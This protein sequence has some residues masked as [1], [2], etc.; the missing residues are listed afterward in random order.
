[1]AGLYAGE[2]IKR[3]VA[4]VLVA[5][6]LG[7]ALV[8]VISVE[9]VPAR[10]ANTSTVEGTPDLNASAPDARLSAGQEGTVGITITNDATIEDD[11][12]THPAEAINRAGEARSVRVN[13]TDTEDAP[14]TVETGQQSGGTIQDGETSGP[15]NFNVLVDED[16]KAGTYEMEV[17]TR[18]R[19]AKTVEYEQTEPGTYQY[20]EEV[21][22]RTETETITVVIEPEA[23]FEIT[24]IDHNIPLGGEGM[25]GLT[26]ENTGDEDITE[27][28]V[29]VNSGDS[30]LYFGSGTATSEAKIGAWDAGETKRVV[31]RA[32][33]V[34]AAVQ[35]SYPVDLTVD[36]T[37]S[38]NNQASGSEQF[39]ITPHNRTRFEV[40]NVSH[41]VPRDGTGTFT[42]GIEHTADKTISDVAVTASTSE[43]EVSLGSESSRSA[44]AFVREWESGETQNLTFRIGASAN[45]V[46][47]S[48]PIE[49]SFEYTDENNSDNTRTEFVE[50]TPK[51]RPQFSV[52]NVDHDVPVGGAGTVAITLNNKGPI[53]ATSAS[54]TVSSDV[55]ALYFGTGGSTE[56]VEAAGVSFQPPQTGT[57]T[58]SAYVG[59]WPVGENRTLYFRAGFD[60]NAIEREYTASLTVNYENEAGNE[61]PARSKSIGLQ[62]LPEPTFGL[63]AVETDLYVGEEGNL[64]G[65]VT[66]KGNRTAEGLV[67]S[68]ESTFQNINIYN[69]QYAVGSLEP[70]ESTTFRYRVGV[71]EEAEHGPRLFE[72]SARYRDPDGQIRNTE[73]RDLIVEISPDRNAFAIEATNATLSPGESGT[74][75]LTVT[76]MR[77]ETV[78]DVQAKLFTDDPL[79]S[80]DD[81]AFVSELASGE[82]KE[83]KLDLTAGG[84]AMAKEYSVSLDFRYDNARGESIL[85]DTYRVPIT[86]QESDS[87]LDVTMVLGIVPI[88]LILGAVGWRLGA[89]ASLREWYG[90]RGTLDRL[91]SVYRNRFD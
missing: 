66:N 85:S 45:A 41:N 67:L 68:L 51:E 5:A 34:E 55:N 83:I 25:V 79:D 12:E 39:G 76:N 78:T 47:R 11:G 86:V 13:I 35:R 17:T 87:G 60:Q 70:G 3:L 29:T 28:A 46:I 48:Y 16:A 22:S 31:F 84:T 65:N 18:Y 58:S 53:N 80:E 36:Y 38:D 24:D 91:R 71:T 82:S 88:A 64:I 56:P 54:L 30:D 14:L 44:S 37:D 7:S 90:D 59:D 69:P 40:E 21:V 23:R 9:S 81:E 62:P 75:V 74:L 27:S 43:S 19:H 2:P 72:L 33:T 49:L 57:P 8:G 1:M 4:V 52:Q 10:A 50:F 63:E 42:V 20:N 15:Y 6:V 73:S 61:M 26:V 32:G 77:N 89:L